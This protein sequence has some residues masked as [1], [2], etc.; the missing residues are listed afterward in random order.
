MNQY[1]AKRNLRTMGL[2]NSPGLGEPFTARK[3]PMAPSGLSKDSCSV[4]VVMVD[5]GIAVTVLAMLERWT[6]KRGQDPST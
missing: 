2:D 1:A 5:E 6:S 3:P 4:E